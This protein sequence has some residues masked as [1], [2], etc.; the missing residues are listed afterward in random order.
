MKCFTIGIKRIALVNL[1]VNLLQTNTFLNLGFIIFVQIF[2]KVNFHTLRI[3]AIDRETPQAVSISFDVPSDLKSDFSFL[4]GQYLTLETGINGRQVRRAYSLC[5]NPKSGDLRVVVKKVDGGTF[6]SFANSELQV[7][8]EIKVG[9]PMGRFT[10]SIDEQNERHL[11]GIA[12]GSGI[13]PIKSILLSILEG[14]P[15]SCFTLIYGNKSPAETIFF[16]ELN[17]LKTRFNDRFRYYQ[18]YSQTHIEDSFFG[19]IDRS[20]IWNVMNKLPDSL[21]VENFFICGPNDM[22]D[23][24]TLALLERGFDKEQIHI[25]LFTSSEQEE[26]GAVAE[27]SEGECFVKV[28]VDEEEVSFSMS[29]DKTI[30]ESALEHDVDAPYS[31]QGGICSTCIAKITEGE[32]KMRQNNVLTDEEIEE[33]FVLTCQAEPLTSTLVV[34]YDDV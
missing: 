1:S 26:T 19:R 9:L 18:A 12:A 32:A 8:E 22:I 11:L 14:E 31:C 30:L 13:T 23:N 28:I 5:T 17:A 6:S 16:D 21:P 33:G 25:E 20:I 15:N 2:L 7:G 10:V 24:S 29:K 34:D 27:V 3:K 4:P